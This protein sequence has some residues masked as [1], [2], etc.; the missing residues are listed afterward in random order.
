MSQMPGS[1][2]RKRV[3]LPRIQIMA[4]LETSYFVRSFSTLW[5]NSYEQF[6]YNVLGNSY[7]QFPL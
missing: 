2:S 5:G 6:P 3:I 4:I 1:E 7:E